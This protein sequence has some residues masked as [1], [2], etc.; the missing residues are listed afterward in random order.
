MTDD[1][2]PDTVP[3]TAEAPADA[4]SPGIASP[5]TSVCRMDQDGLYCVGCFRTLDEIAGWSAFDDARRR[6][7]WE[8]L[9]RRKAAMTAQAVCESR[10]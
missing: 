2:D 9:N 10:H 6:Q 4:G 1:R 8:E 3:N 7:V 5:C